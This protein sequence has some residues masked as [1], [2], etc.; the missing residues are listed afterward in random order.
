M[1]DR[2]CANVSQ[3]FGSVCTDY[4]NDAFVTMMQL[5]DSPKYL[6]RWDHQ[7]DQRL[8][9]DI[10]STNHRLSELSIFSDQGL[11]STI[12]RYPRDAMTVT[13][14]GDNPAHSSELQYGSFND[15][16]GRTWIDMI[17]RGRLCL[18][19]SNVVQNSDALGEIVQRLCGEMNECQPGLH[20]DSHEGDLW[21]S[22]PYAIHYFGID[23]G[24]TVLWQI[25][26]HRRVSH[27]PPGEPFVSARTLEQVVAN[28][29]TRPLYF[30]PAFDDQAVVSEQKPGDVLGLPLHTPHRIETSGTLS[31]TLTTKYQT[32]QT[33]RRIA[34]LRANE[35]LN[36]WLPNQNRSE[37]LTGIQSFA[38]RIFSRTF[39]DQPTATPEPS[40]RVDC[41][42]SQCVGPIE[43]DL[44]EPQTQSTFPIFPG[45]ATESASYAPTGTE[46]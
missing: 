17:R 32:R 39:G 20:T 6:V 26:G 8:L 4:P 9:R 33:H 27:Y 18:R 15:H 19:L 24:P 43:A 46:N 23:H 45:L 21:I 40:F 22:S 14:M 3:W 35:R 38:K 5:A 44:V 34:V 11:A 31:L 30:E 28:R 13:T 37:S 41:N 42:A 25:R 16:D 2:R 29:Q 7:C 36:R 1:N 12:D 10:V